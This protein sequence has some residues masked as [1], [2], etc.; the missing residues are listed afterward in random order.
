MLVHDPALVGRGESS[1]AVVHT[2][3]RHPLFWPAVW[4]IPGTVFFLL[5][6]VDGYAGMLFMVFLYFPLPILPLGVVLV[7]GSSGVKR[8]IGPD[9]CAGIPWEEVRE[10]EA[11]IWGYEVGATKNRT[12]RFRAARLFGH[13]HALHAVRLLLVQYGRVHNIRMGGKLMSHRAAQ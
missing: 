2:A 12:V 5:A 9:G 10:I 6:L 13:R 8:W 11:S 7:P 1:G 4:G 3:K